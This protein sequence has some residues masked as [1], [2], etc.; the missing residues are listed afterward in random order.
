[1]LTSAQLADAL[2]AGKHSGFTVM[3]EREPLL[4]EVDV[5]TASDPAC[6]P[7]ADLTSVKPKH[8]PTGTVWAVLQDK[9]GNT[10]GSVV[11]SSFAPGEAKVWMSELNAA[12]TTCKSFSASSQRGWSTPGT[13]AARQASGVGDESLSYSLTA[14][15]APD[16]QQIMTVVRTGGSL[17]VYLTPSDGQRPP[18][19]L[20]KL[21]H[22]QLAAA[23]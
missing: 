21:Q 10:G 18:T 15:E 6:Q 9:N 20:M 4:D 12:L 14:D 7:V 5:V 17:A 23:G 8:R 13:L 2:L 3:P 19:A 1:M 16:K 11:L 22:E